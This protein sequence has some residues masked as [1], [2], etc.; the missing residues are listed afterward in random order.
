MSA[1]Y[2]TQ[3]TPTVYPAD[4]FDPQADAE[5]LRN[6]MKGFGTDEQALTD[7]LGRRSITQRLEIAEAFKTMYGKDLAKEIKSEVGGNFE[8]VL[9]ALL[10]P[11]PNFYAGELHHAIQGL[12]TD[13]QALV[14]VLCTLSNY[15]VQAVAKDLVAELKSELGGVFEDVILSLLT[16]LPEYYAKELHHAI[17]GLGTDEL[18]LV[19]VL[20]TLSNYGIRTVAATYE[21]L[22][23]RPLEKDLKG[24]TSGHFKRLLVSL[25]TA[26]RDENVDIDLAAAHADAEALL[27]AGEN[28]WGTDESTFN[29]IL[30]SRSYAHL[31]QVFR[32]YEQLAGHDIETAIKREFAGSMEDGFLSIAKCVKDKTAYF[33]ERL[34]DAMAGAGTND[35]TLIRIIVARSEIDLG[36]VKEAFL[37]IYGKC[38]EDRIESDCSGDY[39]KLLI[40][41][42]A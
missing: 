39:K 20:C 22:Y 3:C 33:A 23:E 6:A 13:E 16:S 10:T 38:L 11:L 7:V 8:T 14:E 37:R 42:V 2:P 9:V 41:L 25:C 35:R 32:E 28:Q 30:V 24:D 1:Y 12:G 15:G 34:H 21:K 4:P 36:D 29:M 19:E 26:N 18:A 27:N 5:T 31:R 40:T 17:Q